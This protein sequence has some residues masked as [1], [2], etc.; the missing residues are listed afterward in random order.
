[1]KISRVRF[2]NAEGGRIGRTRIANGEMGLSTTSPY[3]RDRVR[4]STWVRTQID[5]FKSEHHKAEYSYEEMKRLR[6]YLSEAINE[7]EMGE[8]K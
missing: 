6:D 8:R 5:D 3:E 1:M 4:V 7:A 2:N